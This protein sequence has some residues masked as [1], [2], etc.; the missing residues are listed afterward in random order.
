MN[1]KVPMRH[2]RILLVTALT[3][4]GLALVSP[5]SAQADSPA[6]AGPTW[7]MVSA[8]GS[9]TC[10]ILSND[11]LYCWGDNTDGQIGRNTGNPFYDKP[12]EVGGGRWT[13][14]SAGGDSTCA[15]R[16]THRLFCWGDD[17]SGQVGDGG[18][19]TDRLV[20]TQV[21]GGHTDWT[22][23]QTAGDHTCGR[24]SNGRLYCWGGDG[25]G[26]LGDNPTF[27]QRS[28][29]T[30]VAGGATNWT[31]V[32]VGE[33]HSCGRRTNGRLY[34]WGGD[35]YGTLGDGAGETTSGTPRL[36]AGGFTDWTVV[37][38]GGFTTCARRANARLYC[39]GSDYAGNVGDGGTMDTDRFVPTLVSGGNVS[40]ASVSAGY[41]HAC[42]RRST[43]RILCWGDNG[44]G[45][46]GDGQDN[47][48]KSAPVTLFGD[49]SNWTLLSA[50]NAHTCA[51]KTTGTLWCWGAN[52]H[53][54][55]GIGGTNGESAP[56]RVD[57]PPQ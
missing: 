19:N 22:A 26:E 34:C 24:R 27:A 14:V 2:V 1:R 41:Y 30:P 4:A 16:P 17:G 54:Q 11:R 18:T 29:P 7:R 20:P 3:L 37:D 42:G 31:S 43:G 50:G 36:V 25:F 51:R 56:A 55:L 49:P 53:H 21:A 33:D 9:H 52:A 12:V 6:E 47:S 57:V 48:D 44:N 45:Q 39:W 8:G 13:T 46:L 32:T 40:W 5:T 23:V 15:L 10:G 38:A 28:V 35:S